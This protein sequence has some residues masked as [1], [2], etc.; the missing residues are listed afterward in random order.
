M[1]PPLL[2]CGRVHP[3][4][5]DLGQ[6]CHATAAAAA[7]VRTRHR[8]ILLSKGYAMLGR[9]WFEQEASDDVDT[10]LLEVWIETSAPPRFQP[11]YRCE[12]TGTASPGV[13]KWPHDD[14]VHAHPNA[15]PRE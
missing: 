7:A 1:I 4:L 13:E 5:E 11:V 10:H 6:G 3:W 9:S 8:L 2:Q 12:W 15:C 14:E